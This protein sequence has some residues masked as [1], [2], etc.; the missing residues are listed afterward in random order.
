MNKKD[1][2]KWIQISRTTGAQ[3]PG[4]RADCG[5]AKSEEGSPGTSA[6]GQ[7]ALLKTE[8]AETP[9]FKQKCW[10][11]CDLNLKLSKWFHISRKEDEMVVGCLVGLDVGVMTATS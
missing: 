2:L 10:P 6:E 4:V 7:R 3:E 1:F 9:L 11:V 5:G 8:A